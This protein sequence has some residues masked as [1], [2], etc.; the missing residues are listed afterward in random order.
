[1]LARSVYAEGI[2]SNTSRRGFFRTVAAGVA[3][4]AA[5][6]AV[7]AL[8]IP[9]APLPHGASTHAA[10]KEML[11]EDKYLSWFYAM[12]VGDCDGRTL[13]ASVPVKFIKNWI[14]NHYSAELLTAARTEFFGV[15]HVELVARA[16][17][18][19]SSDR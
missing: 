16:G 10:L 9:V 17:R 5:S 7:N 2:M 3:A 13:H 18:L 6:R 4:L 8:P 1:M 19:R 15:Q 12:R 14:D 11:G